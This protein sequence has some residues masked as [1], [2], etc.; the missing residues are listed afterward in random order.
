[1]S[2]RGALDCEELHI[3]FKASF[4][5]RA[6]KTPALAMLHLLAKCKL[7]KGRA[8][9]ISFTILSPALSIVPNTLNKY[10]LLKKIELSKPSFPHL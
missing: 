8:V 3:S 7:P 10:L 1:M 6:M 9:F 2:P 5:I 4:R